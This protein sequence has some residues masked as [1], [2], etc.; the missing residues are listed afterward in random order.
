MNV[1]LATPV[2]LDNPVEWSIAVQELEVGV[3]YRRLVSGPVTQLNGDVEIAVGLG[4]FSQQRIHAPAAIDPESDAT[5]LQKCNDLENIFRF[6]SDELIPTRHTAMD[7]V[8]GCIRL[9]SKLR[10]VAKPSAE[11]DQ[12]ATIRQL[13]SNDIPECVSLGLEAFRPVYSSMEERYGKDLFDR[14]R[15]DWESTQSEMIESLCLADD[16][17]SFVAVTDDSVSGFVVAKPDGATGL[18]DVDMVAVHPDQQRSGL[19]ATLIECSLDWLRQ[20]GMVYA[21]AF[22]R[23]FSGH[24]PARIAFEKVGFTSMP[25]Q[26]LPLYMKLGSMEPSVERSPNIRRI[27]EADVAA[28]VRF[29]LE[30]FRPVFASFERRHGADVF[31][32][33]FPE[34]ENSQAEYMES[35]CTSTDKE[36]WVYEKGGAVSGFMVL[37]TNDQ[38]LGGIELLAV[39]PDKQGHGVGTALNAFGLDRLREAGMVYA[40]VSTA[41]DPGH[42]PARRSYEK[43]GFIPMPIQWNLLIAKL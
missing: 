14:L 21:Q 18:A 4:L 28:C 31:P 40:I 35:A 25:M 41:N 13:T 15:P 43:V 2:I 38:M 17:K 23:D 42:A 10:L 1:D 27:A 30:S 34:W 22:T 9:I 6:H 39:D 32:R 12:M 19:G 7:A 20:S 26:P 36:T 11:R 16:R 3:C 24:E 5:I 33:M 29:G 8:V 37:T